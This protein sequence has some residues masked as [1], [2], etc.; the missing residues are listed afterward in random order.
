MEGWRLLCCCFR[1]AGSRIEVM[2]PSGAHDQTVIRLSLRW[3]LLAV[4]IVLIVGTLGGLVG[5]RFS[6]SP[7]QPLTSN[8]DQ[9]VTTV[10]EVSISPS[11]VT[12]ELVAEHE[13]SVFLLARG[14][15]ASAS[16]FAVASV[17]TND[18]LLAS[19]HPEGKGD[20]FGIDT[21]GALIPLE[22]V[23]RDVVYD[24]YYYRLRD[25]VV[26][27]LDL[28]QANPTVGARSLAIWRSQETNT[29]IAQ[30]RMITEIILPRSNHAVGV[31][32]VGRLNSELVL[33]GTPLLDDTGAL[34]GL[35]DAAAQTTIM[36]EDIRR[37][38]ERI[39]TGNRETNPYDK[40]GF[41]PEFLFS[42]ASD[43]V[44]ATFRVEIASVASRTPAAGQLLAGDT[45]LAVSD[46]ETTWGDSLVELLSQSQSVEVTISRG[47]QEQTVSL[48]V[49]EEGQ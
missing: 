12:Q 16:V 24:I 35:A 43:S 17:I 21:T 44:P 5:S 40:F 34:V 20:V 26:A 39:T 14:T 32:Q 49:T 19:I 23:G 18:G 25:G 3:V 11:K 2:D 7:R 9:I 38:M 28:A 22:T 31:Q 6:G 45:L 46:T 37:S 48:Q 4:V 42:P 47:E 8:R 10:Q 33:S 27:P 29:P 36:I 41:T 15:T 13:R 1:P 30:E